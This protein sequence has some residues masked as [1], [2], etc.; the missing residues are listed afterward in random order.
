M[1]YKLQPLNTVKVFFGGGERVETKSYNCFAFQWLCLGMDNQGFALHQVKVYN[2]KHL[3]CFGWS[4]MYRDRLGLYSPHKA[5]SLRHISTVQEFMGIR[6]PQS[7]YKP[8]QRSC[9]LICDPRPHVQFKVIAGLKKATKL[10]SVYL[11]L[12]PGSLLG[13]KKKRASQRATV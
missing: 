11:E 8:G 6:N 9:F 3:F 4:N 13:Y 2:L 5:W 12:S 10:P 1:I 7:V